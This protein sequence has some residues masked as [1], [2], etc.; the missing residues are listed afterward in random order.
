MRGWWPVAFALA[1]TLAS[2][3]WSAPLEAYGKLPRIE[4]AA[5]SP[6]GQMLALVETDGEARTL[7]FEKA[8]TRATVLKLIVG[9]QKLRAIQWAGPH[10]L[11]TTVSYTG[12]I[13]DVIAPRG[14]WNYPLDIDW[15]KGTLRPMLWG[16]RDT[17]GVI[18]GPIDVRQIDGRPMAFVRGVTMLPT[19][20]RTT[21]FRVDLDAG[22]STPRV[23]GFPDT[24]SFVVDGAG[25]VVA[26]EQYEPRAGRWSLDLWNNGWTEAEYTTSLNAP[27]AVEGLGRDATSVAIASD[28]KDGPV[29][30]ELKRDGTEVGPPYPVDDPDRLIWDP[31][32]HRLI[33]DAALVGDQAR[34]KFFDPQDQASWDS[35]NAAFPGSRVELASFS[36]D[37]KKFVVRVDSP[38]AGPNYVLADVGAKTNVPIGD[39]YEGLTS[40]DIA[41]VKPIAFV[42][43]D[44]LALSGYLTLPQGR[45]PSRLP[46]IVFPH[47]GPAARDEPGFDWWAQA[48]A[49]RG[50]AVLQ[51]NF[52][53]SSGL[54]WTLQSAG[55]G[56]WGRK[57][58]TDLSDG[59]RY[60]AAQGTIDP[61][62]VCI[63]GA[64]YGGYAALAGATLD[65]GVYRCAASVAGPSQL[66]KMIDFAASDKQHDG[67]DVRRYWT[68]YMG[69]PAKLREISPANLAD[70]VTIPI[71]LVHGKDDTVV[72]FSQSQTMVDALTRARKPSQFV[73]LKSEDHWLSRGAT[74]LQMLQAVMTFLETYN[75]PG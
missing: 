39:L 75:P 59:V 56:E 37:H 55:F 67:V 31:A 19:G 36:D 17:L 7:T 26:Q 50:Y 47:G 32:T 74:R 25:L 8:D 35:I 41:T 16:L 52:R 18:D 22:I 4:Q 34:Y 61:A 63:V 69:D 40:R 68:R 70:K 66:A 5:I 6:D 48:M 2:P 60:L 54:G 27:P 9:K 46:L 42:A 23:V 51:V 11:I 44:G 64:S 58:Q 45:D 57:M 1:A 29:I 71:L 14:E 72:D 21:V 30:G 49:S 65:P 43:K 73:T 28:G 33:G 62:R 53:G 10:H 15:S 20:G 12:R 3:C 24:I 38:T 13:P